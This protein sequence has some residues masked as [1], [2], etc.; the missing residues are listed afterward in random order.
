MYLIVSL[1]VM[2][3]LLIYTTTSNVYYVMPEEDENIANTETH[4]LQHY[5]DNPVKYFTSN[6]RLQFLAGTH[7]FYDNLVVKNVTNFLLVGSHMAIIY[8][9]FAAILM[10]HADAV[11]ISNIFVKRNSSIELPLLVA[12]NTLFKHFYTRFSFHMSLKG[13]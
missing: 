8:S 7:Y 2:L 13:L 11:I 6:T 5:V 12:T 9:Q 1:G 4:T 3:I 10:D